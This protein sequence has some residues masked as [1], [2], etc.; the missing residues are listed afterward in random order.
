MIRSTLR[1]T[2]TTPVAARGMVVAEHPLGA[3]VGASILARGGNAVDAA[4]ATA[5][6]MP[7]VEPF[8]SSIAGGGS[9]LIHM[10]KRGETAAIDANVAAPAAA[11]ETCYEL[12]EGL[13][14]DLFPWRRVVGDANVFGPKAVAVP[15]SVAGLALALA[16]FGTMALADVIAPAIRLA[17]EG[18]VPDW[19]VAQTMSL[20]TRELRAFPESART[21]LRDGID[22]YR[23]P[24]SKDGD[25]LR[26]PDLARTLRLIAKEGPDAFYRGAIAEAIHAEVQGRGGFLTREDLAAYEAR[27]LSPLR[28]DY[29]G[30]ELAFMPGAT[31]GIT[32]LEILNLLAAFPSSAVTYKSAGGLHI[33]AEAVRLA[34]RDRFQHLGDALRVTAPWDGLASRDYARTLAKQIKPNGPRSNTPAPDPW[35]YGAATISGGPDMAPALPQRRTARAHAISGSPD[36]TTH[37]GCIDRQRNMVSFTNTAVSLFGAR[38][39]VPG[40]GVL[41][42]NG[43]IWFDP[44]PGRVNSIAPG[45][46]PLVNMV[47]VLAFRKGEPVYTL[48]A[49][50]GRKIVSVIPQVISNMA[51]A[52]DGPQPAMEA[53]RLHDE[54]GELLVDDRVGDAALAA[55]RKRKHP[56]TPKDCTVGNMY[57]ARPIAIRITKKG[58]EAGLDPTSDASA[59]GH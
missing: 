54:G 7:V 40:T 30:L 57:F 41:L 6:A 38:M 25:V 33:R 3:G 44:E 29:R 59:A 19:Y 50:G 53:P 45:K 1:M 58:L 26:Q 21:Y 55:L 27:L 49:P 23:P 46:R 28:G 10:A 5:F 51:D 56:V 17:E 22:I 32:A 34:F 24:V 36:C 11:H 43:M 15:G 9:F 16:R 52:G 13:G 37:I 14:D 31:G 48:G 20:Y 8:M 12:G 42:Q 2:K 18:F 47:P 39:V 4:V 35:K